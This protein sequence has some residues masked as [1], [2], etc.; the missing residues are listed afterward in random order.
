MSDLADSPTNGINASDK[1]EKQVLIRSSRTRDSNSCYVY[2]LAC[3]AG[4]GGFLFGY[5]T[6]VVSGAMLLLIREFSLSQ[7][8][9]ELVVSITIATAIVGAVV[10]GYANDKLGRRPFLWICSTVFTAG[11]VL[12]ALAKSRE[13]LLVGRSIVGFAIGE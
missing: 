8:W 9:Q 10:A 6:G 13:V 5:D 11:A 2:F 1:D 7:E 12:M 4:C 3:F